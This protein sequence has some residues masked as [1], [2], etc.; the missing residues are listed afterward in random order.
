MDHLQWDV[1]Y[2]TWIRFPFCCEPDVSIQVYRSYFQPIASFQESATSL[3]LQQQ[4]DVHN[5][6]CSVEY[7]EVLNV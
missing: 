3:D 7:M 5:R 1:D 4:I 6:R 2:L